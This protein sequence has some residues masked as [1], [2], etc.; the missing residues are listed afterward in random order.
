[1]V[2]HPVWDVRHVNSQ[3]SLDYARQRDA[4]DPVGFISREFRAARRC[5]GHAAAVPVRPFAGADAARG[6]RH[7]LGGVGPIGPVSACADMRRRGAPWIYYP[8]NLR[9]DLAGLVGCAA[10]DV[11]AMNSLTINL[12]LM[13]ASFYRPQGRRSRIVIEAGGL[14][15]GPACRRIADRMAW[16]GSTDTSDRTRTAGG[17][18]S[19]TGSGH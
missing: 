3:S 16:V 18:G 8:E 7:S 10:E 13:L 2:L 14:L 9:D 15:V 11:I 12:H 19:D 6:A 4:A 17:G 5:G 1:M